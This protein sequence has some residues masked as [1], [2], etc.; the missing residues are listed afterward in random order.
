MRIR[1]LFGDFGTF[2]VRPTDGSRRSILIQSDMEYPSVAATFGWD[3]CAVQRAIV[4]YHEGN[5]LKNCQ[6]EST[7]GTVDCKCGVTA[8][9]FIAHAHHWL[10]SCIGSIVDDPGY[11]SENEDHP[12]E[13]APF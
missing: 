6:H 9:D 3:K 11:F 2:L 10:V 1:L 5:F 13:P 7:D 12:N 4:D 8:M